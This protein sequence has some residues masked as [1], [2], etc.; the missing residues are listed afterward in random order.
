MG[1]HTVNVDTLAIPAHETPDR[2]GVPHVVDARPPGA[3]LFTP[4]EAIAEQACVK[5]VSDPG[6]DLVYPNPMYSNAAKYY[7]ADNY[8]QAIK[9]VQDIAGG[10]VCTV[11]SKK[12]LDNPE[13]RPLLEKYLTAKHGIPAEDRMKAFRLI[14]DMTSSWHSVLTIHG[15]GSLATQKMSILALADLNRYKSAARRV[16]RIKSEDD[17]PF[18]KDLPDYPPKL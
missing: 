10:L 6:S 15:E 4:T 12:D 9:H 16:A 7:F 2:H 3:S 14:K 5:C 11:P 17:H 8:H 1:D 13:T 18:Y